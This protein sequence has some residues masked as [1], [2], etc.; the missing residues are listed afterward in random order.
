MKV[1]RYSSPDQSGRNSIA[2]PPFMTGGMLIVILV[3]C[4][5]HNEV[6]AKLQFCNRTGAK[7]TVAIAYV[8]KD[9]PGVSTGGH[10]GVTVE[11]WWGIDP[12]QCKVVSNIDAGN[13][14]VYYHA[15][16]SD[17]QWAGNSLLCVSGRSFETKDLFKRQGDR[18]PAGYHLKGFKRID[19]TKRNYTLNLTR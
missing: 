17:G 12:N 11:G 5:F 6:E 10:K 7:A 13:H 15:R 9:P 8:E 1:N 16:S 2:R 18:C 3:V 4:G 14:W 19:A